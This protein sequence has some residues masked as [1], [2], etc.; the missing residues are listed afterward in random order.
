MLFRSNY[1]TAVLATAIIVA[2]LIIAAALAVSINQRSAMSSAARTWDQRQAQES[3]ILAFVV[4]RNPD[5][6]IKDFADFPRVLLD[7]SAR[8]G[9][10]YRLVMAIIDKESEFKPRAVSYAGAMG[11]MQLMPN[12]AALMAKSLDMKD[13][14]PPKFKAGKIE[15]WGT[16]GDPKTNLRLGLEYFR[17][18]VKKFGPTAVAIRGYN[19]KPESATA[20]WPNDRYAEEIALQYVRLAHTFPA[21]R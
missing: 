2:A 14:E 8:A 16:L 13:Y 5:A 19:R 9:L 7:E 20:H 1:W 12:T 18:Q 11:L 17:L 4:E 15:S 21:V 3:R 6:T 10:D